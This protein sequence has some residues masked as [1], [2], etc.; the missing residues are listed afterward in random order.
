MFSSWNP[1]T[2]LFDTTHTE[3]R[4]SGEN[5]PIPSKSGILVQLEIR[6]LHRKRLFYPLLNDIGRFVWVCRC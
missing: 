6:L 2:Y 1:K 4:Q 5:P 3:R